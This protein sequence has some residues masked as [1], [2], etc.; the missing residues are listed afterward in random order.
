MMNRG[1][2]DDW[3]ETKV[4]PKAGFRLFCFPHVG[5][6][7]HVFRGW[8]K[9]LS[10]AQVCP[11]LLPGRE[12]RLNE[13]PCDRLSILVQTLADVIPDGKPFAFFGHSMGALIAFELAREFRRRG[14]CGPAHIFLAAL[15]AVHCMLH[16]DPPRYLL[17]D[18]DFIEELRRVKGTP[19]EVLNDASLMEMLMPALRADYALLE[20]YHYVDEGLLD[21]P[22]TAF[23]GQEDDEAREQHLRAWA[24]YTTGRFGLHMFPGGHFFLHEV[25]PKIF[26]NIVQSMRTAMNRPVNYGQSSLCLP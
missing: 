15:P 19:E 6:T 3:F 21:C 11:V 1:N 22:I 12:R 13:Q 7:H 16:L 9:G 17:S 14:R 25:K 23:G 8:A 18:A 24:V 5:G 10:E 20:T 2:Y 4:N 26:A